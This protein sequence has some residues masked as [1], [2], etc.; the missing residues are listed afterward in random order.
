MP[1]ELPAYADVRML[2]R[3]AFCRVTPPKFILPFG[4]PRRYLRS[5][6]CTGPTAARMSK[7]SSPEEQ[8]PDWASVVMFAHNYAQLRQ[9]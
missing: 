8:H 2:P 9:A 5:A 7:K 3:A 4:F 1:A 6:R